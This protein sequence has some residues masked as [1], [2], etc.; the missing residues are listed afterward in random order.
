[1]KLEVQFRICA[2][3]ML[4]L[5]ALLKP[6]IYSMCISLLLCTLC[7]VILYMACGAEKAEK[8]I[9]KKFYN[10]CY[11]FYKMSRKQ[12]AESTLI[13]SFMLLN[14]SVGN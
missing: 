6:Q 2:P 1:M 9:N 3:N 7:Y 4:Y 8:K 10:M 14:N 12:Y 13:P 11:I 5:A